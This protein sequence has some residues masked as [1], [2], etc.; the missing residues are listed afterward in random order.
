M[1]PQLSTKALK[2]LRSLALTYFTLILLCMVL[3]QPVSASAVYDG[4]VLVGETVTVADQEIKV[5]AAV[6]DDWE[7]LL[8]DTGEGSFIISKADCKRGSYYEFCYTESRYELGVYGEWDYTTLT[9]IPE[10]HLVVNDISPRIT[11]SA[12]TDRSSLAVNEQ[13]TIT[14]TVKNDGSLAA[15]NLEYTA[16]LPDNVLPLRGS[17]G[18]SISGR[19]ITWKGTSVSGNGGEKE[20]SYTL[21]VEKDEAISF[22]GNL[23]Y[24]YQENSYSKSHPE[25]SI[26][27]VETVKVA[28]FSLSAT[29]ASIN[30]QLTLT[31]L[32]T[33]ADQ[34]YEARINSFE[35]TVPQ[36]LEIVSKESTLSG[37][38][39][40]LSWDGTIPLNGSKSF[41]VVVK[42]IKSGT[43]KFSGV[44]DAEVYSATTRKWLKQNSSHEQTLAVKLSALTPSIEFVLG[45]SSV[46]GGEQTGYR[47][48]LNN[49]D[50]K[51]T[52]FDIEY[53]ITSD[54][55]DEVSETLKFI[56][57]ETKKLVFSNYFN[58][59]IS[60][61]ETTYTINFSGKYRTQN[62]EYFTFTKVAT[63]TV[64]EEIFEQLINL[65]QT[66]PE[67]IQK[68]SS[69]EVVLS[70]RNL[71][72]ND[73]KLLKLTD[74][75][76]GAEVAS[77]TSS[78][79]IN[80]LEPNTSVEAYRYTI[81]V[82]ADT[83]ESA[84]LVKTKAEFDYKDE[85]MKHYT[86]YAENSVSIT[87][88]EGAEPEPWAV[89]PTPP[90]GGP[91][92]PGQPGEVPSEQPVED[93]G[94]FARLINSIKEFF[95]RIF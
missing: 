46:D 10:V 76:T 82:P 77:G 9:E 28:T 12:S 37:T 55:S 60:A 73:I 54:L 15:T 57:P 49:P 69:G 21:R 16:T 63:L 45:K 56:A 59:P 85:T 1:E 78:R 50:T 11:V 81:S 74:T 67:S 52:Y 24:E 22:T 94:F 47:V 51:A 53:T 93:E 34:E 62:N 70:V 38:G 8:L 39:R 5:K 27:V 80:L 3:S 32:I 72:E 23:T 25:V 26:T 58:A 30:E 17:D 65:T 42:T 66:L 4:W 48:H 41:E 18:V 36:G 61:E 87:D 6:G 86:Q 2:Y 71:Q 88:P 19:I 95:Q 33:N 40:V 75:V 89:L 90:E 68:G 35:I 31:T 64:S 84:V 13:A 14:V 29:S 44:M 92:T 83:E 20:F 79:Q 91:G 7:Q 43:Y